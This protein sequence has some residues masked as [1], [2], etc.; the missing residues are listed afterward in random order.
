MKER[1]SGSVLIVD[2]SEANCASLRKLLEGQGY[3]VQTAQGG[4]E[5]LLI[6]DR[7]AFDIVLLD[8]MM[9]D[10]SG[11]EVLSRV[12]RR[13]SVVDLPIIMTTARDASDD[14]VSALEQGASD[15]VTKP[16]DLPVLLARMQT[17]LAL[18]RAIEQIHGL[19]QKLAQRNRELEQANAQLSVVNQHMKQ[20]LDMAAHV[21][22]TFLPPTEIAFPGIEIAWLLKPCAALAGDTLNIFSL[23]ER[24]LGMY[25]VDVSGHGVPAAL[26]AVT[27]SNMLWPRRDPGSVLMRRPEGATE[28]QI[29]QP[30]EV[31][32]LL[33]RRF[34]FGPT[35]EQ[36]FTLLYGILDRVNGEFRYITAGHPGPF[37]APVD[38]PVQLLERPA[39]PIGIGDG[40][41]PETVVTL[42]PGDRLFMYSDGVFETMNARREPFG[43]ARMQAVFDSRREHSLQDN[44]L[45]LWHQLE[46]WCGE[47]PIKDDVSLLAV[48]FTGA[49]VPAAASALLSR[50][51]SL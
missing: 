49:V 21:Q 3:S 1:A 46:Q 34:L 8:V 51:V 14:I 2:D 31:G 28:Y 11:T 43:K 40:V 42:R 33:N 41:Y 13:F 18:K 20:D 39:M 12:R 17:Q 16:L 10:L 19:E 6:L 25:V 44:T 26:M 48:E 37:Y 47:A 9:Q 27:L 29:V 23:D 36:Y 7:Q 35:T 5:A 15:Y 32:G 22:E 24:H 30:A 50:Y 38:G 4:H 45:A